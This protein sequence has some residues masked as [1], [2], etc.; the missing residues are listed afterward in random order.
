MI[1]TPGAERTGKVAPLPD[2]IQFILSE[3]DRQ[4]EVCDALETLIS[5]LD[6]EP[7]SG[8]ASALLGFLTVDLP[9]HIEDEERDL[10]PMLRARCGALGEMGEVL[11]QL[12]VE[13]EE[14]RELASLIVA[15]L[16]ALRDGRAPAHAVRFHSNA[17]AFCE[18]QRRHLIWENRLVL[19]LAARRLS[20][21][22]KAELGQ[23]M[24]ERRMAAT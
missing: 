18:L 16:K 3:H 4:L 7:V 9:L 21:A 20:A 22:D 12:A 14:D 11:E 8:R 10:F 1:Q 13:H 2:P 24:S 19:S 6:L 15:D 17:R 5:V 23:R